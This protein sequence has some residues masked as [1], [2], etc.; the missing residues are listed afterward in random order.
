[1]VYLPSNSHPRHPRQ[2]HLLLHRVKHPSKIAS[3]GLTRVRPGKVDRF[4]CRSS[5][6]TSSI[7]FWSY[8]SFFGL[9]IPSLAWIYR[10]RRATAVRDVILGFAFSGYSATVVN[11]TLW[12][13][14]EA[15]MLESSDVISRLVHPL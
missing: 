7:N 13:T 11:S 4:V 6:V 15:R 9:F 2:T 12:R 10:A 5:R 8:A 14:Q 3:R 1:M